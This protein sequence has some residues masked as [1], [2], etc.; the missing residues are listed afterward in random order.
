VGYWIYFDTLAK[1]V[2]RAIPINKS[3]KYIERED[4]E[5]FIQA[6]INTGRNGREKHVRARSCP[7]TIR[8]TE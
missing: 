3:A 8:P 4:N 7:S 1:A 6:G 2:A 5:F